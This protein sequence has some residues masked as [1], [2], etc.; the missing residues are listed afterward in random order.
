V[1][2]WLFAS[3]TQP[4]QL[5]HDPN[6]LAEQFGWLPGKSTDPTNQLVLV[7]WVLKRAICALKTPT[8]IE[9]QRCT[10]QVN[11][12]RSRSLR[13]SATLDIRFDGAVTPSEWLRV[14]ISLVQ[15]L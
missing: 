10:C 11:D 13:K 12:R 5:C 6:E 15:R 7:V 8:Q 2:C 4:L 3:A 1:L 14:I 9:L